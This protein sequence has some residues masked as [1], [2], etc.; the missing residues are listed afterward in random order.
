METRINHFSDTAHISVAE[1]IC[2]FLLAICP[3]LQHYKGVFESAGVTV[4][5]LVFPYIALKLMQKRIILLKSF[6]ILLPLYMFLLFKVIDHGTS[7]SEIGHVGTYIVY[8]TAFCCG[9]LHPKQLIRTATWIACFACICIVLQYFCYY[10]L[11]FHLQLVPTSLLLNSAEQWVAA[12]QTGLISITGKKMAFYRPSAFFLEPSHMFV[13][14]C[15]P[16]FFAVLSQDSKKSERIKAILLSAGMILSTSGMGILSTVAVWLLYLAKNGGA[17]NRFSMKKLLRPRNVVIFMAF[18]V[19]LGVLYFNTDFFYRS[20][21]RIFSSGSDYTNAV[22]GRVS[23]GTE[24]ISQLRGSQ[25]IFGISD[26]YSDVEFHLT[27]FTG[28][29]YKFGI[30][31]TVLSYLFYAKCLKD[32]D[33]RFFWLDL[34]LIV[35]SFFTPHTHGTFYMLF[36]VIF[37]LQGYQEKEELKVRKYF[38]VAV[39][40]KAFS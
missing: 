1:R 16:M 20:V 3:I 24:F 11:G 39:Q 31:G 23:A 25:L 30:L 40:E 35:A 18:A 36:F 27:G 29:M 26:H 28:T 5:I 2:I 15:A 14:L 38:R 17:N 13:Y 9:C 7:V 21:N 33:G 22:S 32:L 12:A 37:L 8:A 34:L 19:I 6:Q 4:F 10:L